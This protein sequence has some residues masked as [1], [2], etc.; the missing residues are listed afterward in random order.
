MN[1][2]VNPR[3]TALLG[4]ELIDVAP[5]ESAERCPSANIDPNADPRR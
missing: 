1:L 3:R 4:T 5:P 2:P